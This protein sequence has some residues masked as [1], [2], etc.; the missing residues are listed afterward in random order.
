VAITALAL[1]GAGTLLV[2]RSVKPAEATA[3]NVNVLSQSCSVDGRVRIL[4][5]WQPFEQGPQWVDLSLSDNGFFPGTF[6]GYGNLDAGVGSINWDGLMPGRTH[7]L[8][9][10]SL[11]PYGWTP[12]DTISFTTRDCFGQGAGSFV[13]PAPTFA[14][15]NL[16]VVSQECMPDGRVRLVFGWNGPQM[17]SIWADLS[18]TDNRFMPGMF[19]SEG[20]IPAQMTSMTW[21]GL[22]PGQQHFLRLNNYAN[23]G[24]FPS[25]VAT[26]TT[27]T[28]NVF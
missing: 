24:W 19:A 20:N 15:A 12:S 22:M 18:I 23:G 6:V 9:V 17:G 28:C 2:G 1:F 21:D 16:S 5:N 4:L 25:S 8:R 13:V 7:F 14:P 27:R 26:F 3:Y 11:T 10:N